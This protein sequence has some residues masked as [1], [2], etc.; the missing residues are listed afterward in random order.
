VIDPKL[1]SMSAQYAAFGAAIALSCV[2]A[3]VVFRAKTDWF[4]GSAAI[5][6]SVDRR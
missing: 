2:L 1:S 3:V 6:Q 4:L 5:E